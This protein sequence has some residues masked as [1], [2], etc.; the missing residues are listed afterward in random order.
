VA[1]RNPRLSIDGVFVTQPDLLSLDMVV[2]WH[3]PLIVFAHALML[4]R[5]AREKIGVGYAGACRAG[6]SRVSLSREYVEV[7]YPGARVVGVDLVR[8]TCT[9]LKGSVT[10]W[11]RLRH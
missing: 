11:T 8:L 7:A 9:R 5:L 2:L 3:M 10:P 4:L 1:A 6:D